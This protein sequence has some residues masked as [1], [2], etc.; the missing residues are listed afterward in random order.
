[1]SASAN[2]RKQE[3]ECLRL[4]AECLQLADAVHSPSLKLHFIGMAK[5]LSALAV[6]DLSTDTETKI[7]TDQ[8]GPGST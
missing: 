7:S 8:V 1:M 4:E 6:G 2:L 3:L 5:K